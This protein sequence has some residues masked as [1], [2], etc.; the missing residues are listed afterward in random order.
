MAKSSMLGDGCS[1][2]KSGGNDPDFLQCVLTYCYTNTQKAKGRRGCDQRK[3]VN[4]THSSSKSGNIKM[5][6][7]PLKIKKQAT[8][9]LVFVCPFQ[10]R[11]FVAG[12][13]IAFL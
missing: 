1:D 7:G 13:I 3:A 2:H 4:Q 9:T 11:M 12:P 8:A 5:D 6:D 10:D